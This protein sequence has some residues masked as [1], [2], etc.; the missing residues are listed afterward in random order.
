MYQANTAHHRLFRE[1]QVVLSIFMPRCSQPCK[2]ALLDQNSTDVSRCSRFSFQG[3]GFF[4]GFVHDDSDSCLYNCL[5]SLLPPFRFAVTHKEIHVYITA[6]W[7][8]QGHCTICLLLHT[9]VATA[10]LL[11]HCALGC[12]QCLEDKNHLNIFWLPCFWSCWALQPYFTS[13]ILRVPG[14]SIYTG[15]STTAPRCNTFNP[16]I[17]N[18]WVIC[19]VREMRLVRTL[20]G[21]LR[22]K[23]NPSKARKTQLKGAF[24]HVRVNTSIAIDNQDSWLLSNTTLA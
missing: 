24:I 12:L 17:D 16:R 1:G 2:P 18:N 13:L 11:L 3:S 9:A 5:Y 4:P 15:Y 8:Q 22:T 19:C 20:H 23:Q 7:P 10:S 21:K 6:Q 14:F